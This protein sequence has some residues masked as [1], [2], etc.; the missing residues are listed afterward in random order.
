[1]GQTP[2]QRRP[3]RA[4]RQCFKPT[5]IRVAD[6]ECAWLGVG[7]VFVCVLSIAPH[8]NNEDQ[9]CNEAAPGQYLQ[10][11]RMEV[12]PWHPVETK[13]RRHDLI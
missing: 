7:F 3:I 10:F 13:T 9:T 11:G 5:Q 4:R 6:A 2:Y 12:F 1:M 8:C